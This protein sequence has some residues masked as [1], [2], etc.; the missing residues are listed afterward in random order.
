M[1]ADPGRAGIW[2]EANAADTKTD[3]KWRPAGKKEQAVAICQQAV[4]YPAR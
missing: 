4:A 1:T 2:R 3:K